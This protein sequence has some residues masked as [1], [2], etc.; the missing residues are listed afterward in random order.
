MYY[1]DDYE[2]PT[3]QLGTG[4][5]IVCGGIMADLISGCVSFV[6]NCGKCHP[7]GEKHEGAWPEM[8]QDNEVNTVM[9]LVFTNPESIDAV[10]RELEKAKQFME[11]P[12][13]HPWWGKGLEQ[14]Q[15]D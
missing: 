9:R 7:I 8:T 6:D 5:T 14:Y 15:A 2:I 3:V 12:T 13:S 10:I 11:D 4:D 1:E